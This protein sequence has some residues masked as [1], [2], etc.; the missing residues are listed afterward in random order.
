MNPHDP[1]G[2]AGDL[3]AYHDN[4]L[5]ARS[6]ERLERHLA[7]C[8]A[9]R[10]ILTDFAGADALI[11]GLAAPPI[12]EGFAASV[13]ALA[14]REA[15][16]TVMDRAEDPGSPSTVPTEWRGAAR[17]GVLAFFERFFQLLTGLG[18]RRTY[19]GGHLEAFDDCPPDGL[20]G[21]Y[22]RIME[23]SGS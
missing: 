11:A 22:L 13:A 6:R 18:S 5:D 3:P 7:G 17:T 4:E 2:F 19:Q 12:P 9:C 8:A 16:V 14:R 20:S 15:A 1:C 10:R 21:V 23:G